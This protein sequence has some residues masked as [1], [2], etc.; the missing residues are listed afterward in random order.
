MKIRTDVTAGR[1][2]RNHNH[3]L[4][5]RTTLRAGRTDKLATNHSEALRVRTTLRAGRLIPA[6]NVSVQTQ[7]LNSRSWN[8]SSTIRRYRGNTPA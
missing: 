5:V 2:A 4:R 1:V 6:A 8:S 3:A 7:T